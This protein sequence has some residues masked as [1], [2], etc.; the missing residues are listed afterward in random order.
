MQ[1]YFF[2][3]YFFLLKTHSVKSLYYVINKIH[4]TVANK[5]LSIYLNWYPLSLISKKIF[6]LNELGRNISHTQL[7]WTLLCSLL[8]IIFDMFAT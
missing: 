7:I 2:M 3:G 1:N 4:S 8:E 5:Y 6:E